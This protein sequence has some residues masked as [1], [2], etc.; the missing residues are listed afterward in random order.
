MGCT[1]SSVPSY[2]STTLLGMQSIMSGT[3]SKNKKTASGSWRNQVMAQQRA[4]IK[5]CTHYPHTYPSLASFLFHCL[6]LAFSEYE[7]NSR[8]W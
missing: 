2:L 8:A 3:C 4:G 7:V 1:S 5:L 6:S